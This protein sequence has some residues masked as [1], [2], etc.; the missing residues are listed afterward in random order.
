MFN[1]LL[2][3]PLSS[4]LDSLY[5]FLGNYGLSII[6]LTV[7]IRLVLLY[8][9]FKAYQSQI[10]NRN[11]TNPKEI[12]DK[13][14]AL[15]EKLQNSQSKEEQLEINMQIAKITRDNIASMKS[16][17]L[18][19]LIQSPIL[20]GLFFAIRGNDHINNETFLW[21]N[22]G[23]TDFLLIIIAATITL[24][25]VVISTKLNNTTQMKGQSIMYFVAPIMISIS[26]SIMPSAIP[27]YWTVSTLIATVQLFA[28]NLIIK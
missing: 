9:N 14:K 15:Q 22:L 21:F 11:R 27:L 1:N 23:T 24:I 13:I 10:K 12:S 17:C 6:I 3:T 4:F 28:F 19:A 16:G 26:A 2:V 20:L 7:I 5:L 25:Q 18:N 8:P